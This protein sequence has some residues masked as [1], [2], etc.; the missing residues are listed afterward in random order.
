MPAYHTS[1][2]SQPDPRDTYVS[3]FDGKPYRRGSFAEANKRG[4]MATV[5]PVSQRTYEQ[6]PR[7]SGG[8]GTDDGYH[9]SHQGRESDHKRYSNTSFAA[10]RVK[11][12][13][14]SRPVNPE[15]TS[16]ES[17]RGG[18]KQARRKDNPVSR[19]LETA[20]DPSAPD[21]RFSGYECK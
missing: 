16:Q 5:A 3:Q 13:S 12:P 21:K 7:F 10:V 8:R 11:P 19:W 15:H 14:A 2:S 17:Q 20:G 4:T 9:T 18:E 6:K 1:A